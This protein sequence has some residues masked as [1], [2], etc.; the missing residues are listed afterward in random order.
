MNET[1]LKQQIKDYLGFKQVFNYPLVQGLGSYRGVPDRIMH[2]QGRVHYLEVKTPQGKMSEHQE[3]FAL[4]CRE[5]G[6]SYHVI[7][8]IEDLQF[9]VEVG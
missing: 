1:Q 3:N 6:I 4:Q 8:N 9:I 2:F 7:R 5:D